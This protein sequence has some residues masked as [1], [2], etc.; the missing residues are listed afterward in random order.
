MSEDTAIVVRLVSVF[1]LVLLLFV[2]FIAVLGDVNWCIDNYALDR[3]SH[4][5]YY[6][7]NLFGRYIQPQ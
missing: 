6:E 7:N 2:I 1:A 4:C 5:L 3:V